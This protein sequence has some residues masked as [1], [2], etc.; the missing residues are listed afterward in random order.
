VE[1]DLFSSNLLM[2]TSRFNKMAK[3]GNMGFEGITKL[4]EYFGTSLTA[5][6]IK[7]IDAERRPSILM[8]W[9]NNGELSWKRYSETFYNATLGKSFLK[10]ESFNR[11][12]RNS[13]T[14]KAIHG[15]DPENRKFFRNGAT[16]S[17]WFPNAKDFKNDII[18]EEAFPI[19]E[20]GVLTLLYTDAKTFTFSV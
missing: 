9:D 12:V 15:E 5:T 10:G 14:D 7:F 19:G 6:A 8:K 20:F 3:K 16:V 13:A 18:I 2:P 1:A 11:R 4:S 17:T